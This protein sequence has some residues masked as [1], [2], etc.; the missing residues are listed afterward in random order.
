LNLDRTTAVCS[1]AVAKYCAFLAT[2][3]IDKT[4]RIEKIWRGN[5]WKPDEVI[6]EIKQ[7]GE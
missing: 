6:E 3:L 1:A 2:A 5:M 4:G 7:H